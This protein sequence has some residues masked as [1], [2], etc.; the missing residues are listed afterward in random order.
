MMD[1][2][3]DPAI[4]YLETDYKIDFANRNLSN[5][6]TGEFILITKID[7]LLSEC[8]IFKRIEIVS[9]AKYSAIV[10]DPFTEK[11]IDHLNKCV[12]DIQTLVLVN[13]TD[14]IMNLIGIEDNPTK[15]KQL[16]IVETS[17]PQQMT[18]PIG[19]N[20]PELVQLICAATQLSLFDSISNIR[21][22]YID[23]TDDHNHIELDL[24]DIKSPSNFLDID[25]I[26]AFAERNENLNRFSMTFDP[27]GLFLPK[28]NVE[29]E[30]EKYVSV[31]EVAT[32]LMQL[33]TFDY[34]VVRDT[35]TDNIYGYKNQSSQVQ[36]S[37]IPMVSANSE[38][39]NLIIKR[40]NDDKIEELATAL[41]K[42]KTI[43]DTLSVMGKWDAMVDLLLQR[44]SSSERTDD[45]HSSSNTIT[46][47]NH[48]TLQSGADKIVINQANR[49]VESN[50]CQYFDAR[51]VPEN[52][53]SMTVNYNGGDYDLDLMY[54][55]LRVIFV[56]EDLRYLRLRAGSHFTKSFADNVNAN[57]MEVTA[58]PNVPQSTAFLPTLET[59]MIESNSK[60]I[61]PSTIKLLKLHT[62]NQFSL[63]NDMANKPIDAAFERFGGHISVNSQSADYL[64]FPRA[65]TSL[66]I[67][68]DWEFEDEKYLVPLPAPLI[69]LPEE[70]DS[71]LSMDEGEN[72]NQRQRPQREKLSLLIHLQ[73]L[74]A[75]YISNKWI[76]ITPTMSETMS[77]QPKKAHNRILNTIAKMRLVNSG[78]LSKLRTIETDLF[79]N[80]IYEMYDIIMRKSERLATLIIRFTPEQRIAAE[81]LL[82]YLHT[83]DLKF[84]NIGIHKSQIICERV[85]FGTIFRKPRLYRSVCNWVGS[86]TWVG[87]KRSK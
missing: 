63:W 17:G 3:Q 49:T 4:R 7:E 23:A 31:E 67:F 51:L 45:T 26:I 87:D 15:I 6:W 81:Q 77:R 5:Q 1:P 78:Y 59:L 30:V 40:M 55:V 21:T 83:L 48:I 60:E 9:P 66:E 8:G 69:D 27:E 33:R 2:I 39:A 37:V 14:E 57:Y 50:I 38:A 29:G 85:I 22:C 71:S 10:L 32:E 86:F 70:R 13:G 76:Q 54:S 62:L 56:L 73:E 42:R 11:I 52:T 75:L 79:D 65:L 41:H 64:Q 34:L 53:R 20:L 58:I 18:K 24:E 80:E 28:V 19:K 82:A 72:N 68:C 16:Q 46:E 12:D 35:Y 36:T 74:R 61:A 47:I 25:M 44:I 84:W 43:A